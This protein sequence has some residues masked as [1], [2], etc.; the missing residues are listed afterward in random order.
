MPVRPTLID[1]RAKSH[2][3]TNSGAP[4]SPRTLPSPRT[5]HM[6][7]DIPPSMSPLDAFAAQSRL[8]AKK[9]DD[10]SRNGRRVSR[11][12][13]L[14]TAYSVKSTAPP[15][16]LRSRSAEK[17]DA[18][19]DSKFSPKSEEPGIVPE[20]AEPSF[21][22][23][24]FYP[25]MSGVPLPSEGADAEAEDEVFETPAELA[26]HNGS[27]SS[28]NS[29][30]GAPRAQSPEFVATAS[31]SKNDWPTGHVNQRQ[32]IYHPKAQEAPRRDLSSDT[33][34][35]KSQ[36]FNGLVPPQSPQLRQA[37]SVRS[38]PVD[39]SDDDL[40]A[41]TNGSSFSLHRKQSSSSGMSLPRSPLSPFVQ[42]HGRSPSLNSE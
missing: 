13:P 8:L 30:F 3:T 2:E 36:N 38:V 1:F 12:P 7:G 15:G 22:P 6:D 14:T 32:E 41:S 16:Y 29:Y 23:K 19:V 20:V 10:T 25:Q 33:S 9:L 18:A 26:G 5:A 24:S 31:S 11:L 28:G 39:S 21:R 42:V 4:S 37:G 27:G 17:E 40:S 34:S 35:I